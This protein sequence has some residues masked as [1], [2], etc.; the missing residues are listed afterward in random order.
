MQKTN[1]RAKDANGVGFPP[2]IKNGYMRDLEEA[3]GLSQDATGRND[4]SG[5]PFFRVH[6][7]L[8]IYKLSVFISL[9]CTILN[10]KV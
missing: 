2:R 3:C 10:F 6:L 5:Q 8:C 1:A 9:F 7:Y 4:S